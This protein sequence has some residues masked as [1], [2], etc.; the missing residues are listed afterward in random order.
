MQWT[1]RLE[2]TTSAGEVTD[3]GAGG[4]QPAGDGQHARGDRPRARRDQ[5]AFG[6]AAGEHAVRPGGG[7]CGP[8]LGLPGLWDAA[9]AQGPAHTSAADPVRHGRGEGAV[10]QAVPLP[11]ARAHGRGGDILASL[12][13]FDCRPRLRRTRVCAS[14]PT[15]SPCGSRRTTGKPQRRSWLSMTSRTMPQQPMNPGPSSCSMAPTYA[16]RPVIRFGTSRRPT[17]RSR[18]RA[19]QRC[20]LAVTE[21]AL[22]HLMVEVRRLIARGIPEPAI[23]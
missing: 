14:A 3:D 17:A 6:Q 8:P 5:D 9:A 21:S 16:P 7:V 12:H 22:Q 1:V 13:A 11:P 19:V 18:I 20:R 4:V 23:I 15:R 10:V 2:M